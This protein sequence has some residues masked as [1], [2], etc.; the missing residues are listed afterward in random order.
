VYKIIASDLDGTLLNQ[1][2]MVDAY[3]AKTLRWL[4]DNGQHFVIATGRHYLDVI[5]IRLALGIRAHLITSNGARAHDPDNQLIYRENLDP[6]L[7]RKLAQPEIAAG[8][9]L[10]FYLDD[11]WLIDQPSP[12]LQ[13]LHQDSGFQYQVSD[14]AHH[15]GEGVA[16][17]LYVGEHALLLLIEKKIKERFGDRAAITFSALNCLEVMAPG[18]SKGSALSLVLERMG[19][20]ASHCLAFGD[21]QNDLE[22]LQTA[23][24]PRLMGNANPRLV[25]MLPEVQHIGSNHDSGVAR[26]LRQLFNFPD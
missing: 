7:V 3:T 19:L 16:K 8:S 23:G 18:V 5:G 15:S 10:S 24:H 9:L 22:L 6:L 11:A 17:V 26:H 13:A 25:S 20:D 14:L 21:G 12:E 4:T 2:H 1:H